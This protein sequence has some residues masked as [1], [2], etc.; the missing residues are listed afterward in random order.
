MGKALR[1]LNAR[2]AA[3]ALVGRVFLLWLLGGAVVAGRE[4]FSAL[5]IVARWV[6]ACAGTT[7]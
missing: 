1:R 3:H 4:S 5:R 7:V 6:P 2:D